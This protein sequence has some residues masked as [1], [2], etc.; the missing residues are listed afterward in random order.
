MM[1]RYTL[2]S[3]FFDDMDPRGPVALDSSNHYLGVGFE[4]VCF[5]RAQRWKEAMNQSLSDKVES[6]EPPPFFSKHFSCVLDQPIDFYDASIPIFTVKQVKSAGGS[7]D[8][9]ATIRVYVSPYLYLECENSISEARLKVWVS[10]TLAKF[11]QSD[12]YIEETARKS[13]PLRSVSLFNDMDL[14]KL[15]SAKRIFNERY[16]IS[17]HLKSGNGK[18][19]LS[20]LKV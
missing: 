12:V 1:D 10:N 5:G 4:L 20:K 6:G 19:D 3:H 13:S 17:K 14:A 9:V 18:V 16:F 7:I 11:F 2:V 8:S 15:D